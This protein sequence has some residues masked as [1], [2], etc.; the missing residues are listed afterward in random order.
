MI[1]KIHLPESSFRGDPTL[2]PINFNLSPDGPDGRKTFIPES[3]MAGGESASD[4]EIIAAALL[5]RHPIVEEWGCTFVTFKVKDFPQGVFRLTDEDGY[6]W[7]YTLRT[8]RTPDGKIR[9]LYGL[10][11]GDEA[12]FGTFDTTETANHNLKI[13]GKA[14]PMTRSSL[15]NYLDSLVDH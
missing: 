1:R 11:L 14:K 4:A 2:T 9:V 15:L 12:Y 8:A 6:D 10:A 7:L 5:L 3:L 13:K